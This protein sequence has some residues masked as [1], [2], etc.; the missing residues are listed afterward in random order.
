[1]VEYVALH[2]LE[3]CIAMSDQVASGFFALLLIEVTLF[4]GL[5][6]MIGKLNKERQKHKI[7]KEEML[8]RIIQLSKKN[9]NGGGD[10]SRFSANIPL[11]KR[12][13]A[14]KSGNS[15]RT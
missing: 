8:R 15:K 4:V 1:M 3:Q 2:A 9:G 14:N 12:S 13:V 10:E 5:L 7:E 6:I 11:K